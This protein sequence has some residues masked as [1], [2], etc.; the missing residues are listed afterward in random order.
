MPRP[1]AQVIQSGPGM[2]GPYAALEQAVDIQDGI[3]GA[4]R[5]S[6]VNGNSGLGTAGATDTL[7]GV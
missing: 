7:P 6:N 3:Y 4:R 2:P 1:P 5:R